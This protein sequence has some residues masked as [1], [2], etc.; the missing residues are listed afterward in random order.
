MIDR[1]INNKKDCMGCHAC[2]SI[3][4]KSCISMES[5]K[6]GFL[7]PNV[8][9]NLC[10]RCKQCI[11]V[12]PIINKEEVMNDPVAYSCI[13]NDETIRLDSSSGGIFTLVAE[14]VIDRDGAVFGASFNDQSEVVHVFVETKENLEQLRGSKYVQSKIGNSYKKAKEFLDSGREV[15]FTGTPCQI[16]GLKSY[17][18]KL[19][20]NLSTMDI[21][22]HGVPSP[23]VWHKYVEFRET[24]AGSL[25]QRIAFRRKDEGWKRFSVSFLFK[26]NTEYRQNLRNDL[27]MRAFLKDVCLRPACYDCKYKGLNRQSDLT[28]ADFWGVQNILPEMDDDKGTSLIFVNSEMGQRLFNEVKDK[29]LYQEVDINEAVKYNSAAIKSVKYNPKRDGFMAEKESLPFDKLVAKYCNEP[30]QRRIRNK[31]RSGIKKILVKTKLI[32]IVNSARK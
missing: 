19:Y 25:A 3:C 10:I 1:K 8:D 18:E 24:E 22:C 2:A 6:E 23:D 30:L 28:L 4:P 12:C 13:N 32:N 16:A 17:L 31:V 21:V 29:M 26:N 5:D 15:L 9:Y 20:T 7:Y 27:F 11:N 14:N